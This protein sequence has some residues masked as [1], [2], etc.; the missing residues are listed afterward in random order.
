VFFH[1]GL[2]PLFV[3]VFYLVVLRCRCGSIDVA[4]LWAEYVF[5]V[6]RLSYFFLVTKDRRV[7][8]FCALAHGDA[9]EDE[10]L[11]AV[12]SWPRMVL[13]VPPPPSPYQPSVQPT[14]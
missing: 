7:Y 13:K 11:L 2:F 3:V 6:C 1:C 8:A 14:R 9:I 12:V 10:F 4:R 5:I